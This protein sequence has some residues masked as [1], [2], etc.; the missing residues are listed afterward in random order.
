MSQPRHLLKARIGLPSLLI[1]LLFL[2]A[3]FGSQY[4]PRPLERNPHYDSMLAAAR[5]SLEA[6]ALIRQTLIDEGIAIEAEDVN[7]TGLIGPEMSELV[8]SM[9]LLEAKR[10][11]LNPDFAALMVQYYAEA[12]LKAGDRVALGISGSFPGLAIAALSAA[13][14]FNLQARVIA[15]Y[16]ASTYGATRPEMSLPRMLRLLKDAGLVDHELVALSYGGEVDSGPLGLSSDPAAL[17][18][19]LAQQEEVP[20]IEAASLRKN[21]EQRLALF[22]DGIACFVNIGGAS[23]N[24]GQGMASLD[25]PNG[26]A[27]ARPKS[28]DPFAAG[29]LSAYA[30]QG[31]PV[32]HLL[33]IRGLAAQ[34]GLPID[35][36]PLPEPGHGSVYYAKSRPSGLLIGVC[37]LAAFLSLALGRHRASQRISR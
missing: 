36:S 23:A 7:R 37:L 21:M 13:K 34:H 25:F 12:G 4:L 32:I 11:S 1:A 27:M 26:L 31:I 2:L 22:G 15:S 24:T 16:C 8:S 5:R 9:G 10:S 30:N 18:R 20:L 19:S 3:G 17:V 35:P 33:N 29:L 6:Q 28:A 14:E